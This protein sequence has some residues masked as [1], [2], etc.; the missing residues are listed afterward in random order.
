MICH[1]KSSAGHFV[2]RIAFGNL[3]LSSLWTK[4]NHGNEDLVECA[5]RPGDLLSRSGWNRNDKIFRIFKTRPTVDGRNPA[6]VDMVNIPLFTRF[7][8]CWV[9]QDFFHQRYFYNSLEKK[10]LLSR[11]RDLWGIFVSFESKISVQKD[12]LTLNLM[13]TACFLEM[14]SWLQYSS[15]CFSRRRVLP[16]KHFYH[17]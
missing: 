8:A 14:I 6:P 9:V 15:I 4:N 5:C 1:N 2:S 3:D 13:F 11:W 16:F 7:H 17:I 10:D 12:F